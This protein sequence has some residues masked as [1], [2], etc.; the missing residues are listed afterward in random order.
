MS[1]D[2]SSLAPLIVEALRTHS[3]SARIHEIGKYIWDNYESELRSS[4]NFFYKWQYELRWASDYLVHQNTIR[5]GPP[6]GVW[7]I[8]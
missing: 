6:K 5:K 3:G 7:H 4:G 8:V 1:L 2:R